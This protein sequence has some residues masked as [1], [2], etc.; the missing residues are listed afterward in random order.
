MAKTA[1][2]ENFPVGSWLI[3][4]PLRRHVRAFYAFAREADDIADDPDLSGEEKLL[5]LD[6]M[7]GLLDGLS[8][9]LSP[10]LRPHART[11]L[12]A[13]RQDARQDRM[14]DW[15]TLM[16]YC[17]RSAAPVGRMLLDLHGEEPAL[18]PAS[19]ALCAA[20][21]VI[22]HLKDC[23][24]DYRRLARVY[25][26]LDWM[27]AADIADLGAVRSSRALRMVLDQ[28]IAHTWPLLEQAEELTNIRHRRLRL[29]AGIILALARRL[30]KRLEVCDPLA[31]PV[32][33]SPFA[34]LAAVAGGL[35]G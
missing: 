6:A 35:A 15:G 33:L 17:R 24:D 10:V 29:E 11:L 9:A 31:G 28:V 20:L 16:D 19:D 13:F 30:L 32:K 3:P 12:S 2:D 1:A 5:R 25:L 34:K 14:T 27:A 23:G 22:N 4:A 8:P 26:P 7:E 18:Y 21:Q